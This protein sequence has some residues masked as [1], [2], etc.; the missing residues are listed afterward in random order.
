MDSFIF[1]PDISGFTEFVSTTE[2]DHSRSIITDLLTVIVK[3]DR[4]DL[5][6][7]EIEGDAILFY[8]H[9]EVPSPEEIYAQTRHTFLQFHRFLK[10]FKLRNTC[11]CRACTGTGN[12]SLKFIA[13]R[14]ELSFIH[15]DGHKKLY[16]PNVI[17]PHHLLKSDIRSR[18]YLLMSDSFKNTLPFP[19]PLSGSWKRQSQKFNGLGKIDYYY[20]ELSELIQ[21][22]N[23]RLS[24]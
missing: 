12:L 21:P 14:G 24:A 17:L 9:K 8:K 22:S 10:N 16:G 18:E 19:A 13:H 3:S 23:F 1:I 6:V 15:V 2:M 4:L 5:K 20:L 11:G 7:S